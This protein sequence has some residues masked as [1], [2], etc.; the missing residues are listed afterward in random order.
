M[1]VKKP[2][3][4]SNTPADVVQTVSAREVVH[5]ILTFFILIGIISY[6]SYMS[7][8]VIDR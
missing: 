7:F 6:V 2:S 8:A 5:M 3:E 1:I 4:A